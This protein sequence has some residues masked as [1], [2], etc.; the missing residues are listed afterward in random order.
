MTQVRVLLLKH[1]WW[2]QNRVADCLVKEGM[3]GSNIAS[4]RF[5]AVP[6]L[7]AIEA[8]EADSLGTTF[9]RKFQ[10]CNANSHGKTTTLMNITSNF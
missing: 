5:F 1:T 7:H 3:R 2:E 8:F 10:T 9:V 6:P 4:T